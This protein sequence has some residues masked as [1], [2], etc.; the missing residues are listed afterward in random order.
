MQ[1]NIPIF[2]PKKIVETTFKVNKS[3]RT[4]SKVTKRTVAISEAFGIGIDESQRFLIYHN[5]TVEINRGDIVYI[6]GDSG[7]GKSLLLRE[8][9]ARMIKNDN[10]EFGRLITDGEVEREIEPKKPIIEQIG[11]D[12]S[13]AIRTLSLAGLNEAFLMLRRYHELS[14]GQK[15]R[16]KLAKLIDS[17]TDT[18]IM[19]EFLS[20]LDRTTAKV[21]A[22]TIQKAAR[23]L[24]K[25]VIV[26]TTHMDLDKDLNPDVRIFKHFGSCV[27]VDYRKVDR[28]QRCSL[29][30]KIRIEKG[31]INDYNELKQFHY[32]DARIMPKIIYRAVLNDE[33]VGV[34]VYGPPHLM[35]R[36]RNIVMPH[37]KKQKRES[38]RKNALRINRD[39]IRIWRVVIKPKYRGAGIATLL[40]KKTT[41]LTNFPYIE[42]LAVMARYSCFFDEAGMV[43][44]DPELY[45]GYDKRYE[46]ALQRLAALGFDL[47]LLSS[48]SYN[49]KAL[50]RLSENELKEVQRIV[51]AYFI[52][53]KFRKPSMEKDVL[54]GDLESIAKALTGRRLPYV[55]LIW[56]NK[57]FKDKPELQLEQTR[58]EQ[59]E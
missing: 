27:D 2:V 15:Y 53:N 3:F 18:W 55:Y 12:T 23:R 11:R 29:L 4:K 30:Q 9:G 41:P 47:E 43:R 21:V 5:F 31:S 24:G 39:I 6:T 26:A 50:K 36:A 19:D 54:D 35:L 48:K 44:V 56:K 8:L 25:T 22:Y 58:S 20:L 59:M 33:L 49:L 16:F 7:S 40:V 28:N 42:T 1:L 10:G 57:R 34:I 51:S 17:G 32:R 46:S 37:C 38:W 45:L 13:D 52:A 14:D